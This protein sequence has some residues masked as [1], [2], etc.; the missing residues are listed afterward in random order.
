MPLP[1]PD[2][3]LATGPFSVGSL[4]LFERHRSWTGNVVCGTVGLSGNDSAH[5][6]LARLCP[7]FAS[8]EL[9][10]EHVRLNQPAA[11]AGSAEQ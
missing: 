8:T 3:L 10:T 11:S 2:Y 9:L 4:T 1:V 7:H 5:D 6:I